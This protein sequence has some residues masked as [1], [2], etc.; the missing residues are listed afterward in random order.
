MVKINEINEL[1]SSLPPHWNY[2]L[3]RLRSDAKAR[4]WLPLSLGITQHSINDVEALIVA[5]ILEVAKHVCLI[6]AESS[7]CSRDGE[8]KAFA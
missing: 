4:G 2:R 5:C 8:I 1:I 7:R 6:D 3:T